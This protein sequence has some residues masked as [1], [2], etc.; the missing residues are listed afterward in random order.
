MKKIVYIVGTRPNYVKL[1]QLYKIFKFDKKN[2]NIIIDTGQHYSKS[3]NNNFFKEFKISKPD[4]K[5]NK[6]VGKNTQIISKIYSKLPQI[7][8]KICPDK[9]VVFGDTNSSLAG[10]AC[11]SSLD[12]PV[13]HIEAGVRSFDP[14]SQEEKNRVKIGKISTYHFVPTMKAKKNLINEKVIS[15]NIFFC[16]D[17]MFENFTKFKK[18]LKKK[19]IKEKYIFLTLHRSENVDKK[20]K[21]K[22]IINCLSKINQKFINPIHPRTLK[23]FKKFKIKVPNNL[24]LIEPLSY[25]QTLNKI[26]NSQY[27]ITDSGGIQKESYFLKKRCIV[28]RD[29]TEWNEIL[30]PRANI[31]LKTKLKSKRIIKIIE[32]FDHKFSDKKK[33][34]FGTKN[35]AEKI[36]K[37]IIQ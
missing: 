17:I 27:V 6:K 4:I 10:A 22:K 5:I 34:L 19:N 16:G 26:Y 30:S 24:D 14:N 28:L 3:L 35:I 33:N 29:F 11:A 15:K 2:K 13:I 31:L 9:I 37:R 8:Q 21:L 23:N 20:S 12:I 32:N 7:L 18:Y 36:Y 25:Q 1:C